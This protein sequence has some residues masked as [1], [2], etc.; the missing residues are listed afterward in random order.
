MSGPPWDLPPAAP[1]IGAGCVKAEGAD[2]DAGVGAAAGAR[3]GGCQD[4]RWGVETPEAAAEWGRL[5]EAGGS[6]GGGSCGYWCSCACACA[7]GARPP[8]PL[9]P[10]PRAARALPSQPLL[11]LLSGAA[12]AGAAEE[13]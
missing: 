4:M 6:S 5:A 2:S 12:G 3:G 10:L 8:Q 9:L 13:G 7:G 1:R 11:A